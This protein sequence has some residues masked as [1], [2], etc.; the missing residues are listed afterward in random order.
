MTV[1]PR[2]RVAGFTLLEALIA[3]AMMAMILVAL[4]TITA[5][6]L[7]NW[8]RGMTRVQREED[9]ALGL[10]RLTADLAAAQFIPASRETRKPFFNGTGRSVTFVRTNLSP[11]AHAGLEFVRF[12]EVSSATGPAMVRTQAPFKL[13]LDELNKGGT[14]AL[15]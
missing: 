11:N 3:T 4:S 12:A 5:Q 2:S 7:P 13:V 6:W 15:Q 9:L 1:R 10:D 14:T 8:N